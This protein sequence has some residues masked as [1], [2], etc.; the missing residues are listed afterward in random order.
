MRVLLFVLALVAMPFA[1]G[2]AQGPVKPKA[3]AKVGA[4][5]S[6][7]A[8]PAGNSGHVPYGQEKKCPPP[9]P[10]PPAPVPP[11]PPAPV[12]PPPPAPV[13]PPPPAPVPPPPPAPVPPPPPPP[14]AFEPGP[15]KALGRAFK[16]INGDNIQDVFDG[17]DGLPWDVQLYWR[18]TGQLLMTRTADDM[19][20]F[21]FDGLGNGDYYICIVNQGYSQIFPVGTQVCGGLGHAFS[22]NGTFE[23]WA[24]GNNFAEQPPQ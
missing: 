7:C 3:K 8:D 9:A 5:S 22:L 2:V 4:A 23:T 11:P 6:V 24:T 13:P 14:P 17:E 19:G 15:H 18:A 20:D 12:P 10:V 1:V 16:D 21:V